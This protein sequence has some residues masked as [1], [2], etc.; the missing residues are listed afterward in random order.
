MFTKANL[1]NHQQIFFYKIA[2]GQ[3]LVGPIISTYINTLAEKK[4]LLVYTNLVFVNMNSSF[5]DL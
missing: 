1:K 4:N 3:L 5:K 2:N